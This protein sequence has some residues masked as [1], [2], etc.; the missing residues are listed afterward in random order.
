MRRILSIEAFREVTL[1][2]WDDHIDGAERLRF[3]SAYYAESYLRRFV[4]DPGAEA[5]LRCLIELAPTPSLGGDGLDDILRVAGERVFEKRLK[6]YER[7]LTKYFSD[8]P[9]GPTKPDKPDE[10]D[11]PD[12][13]VEPA[14]AKPSPAVAPPARWELE[15]TVDAAEDNDCFDLSTLHLKAKLVEG[16][17]LTPKATFTVLRNGGVVATGEV[18]TAGDA[19]FDWEIARVRDDEDAWTLEFR[20][21]YEDDTYTGNR[22][23]TVWPRTVRLE[24]N[25]FRTDEP[26]KGFRFS[27]E[28]GAGPQI[29]ETGD[30]GVID[31]PLA[32]PAP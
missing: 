29:A 7:A 18:S 15:A 5:S 24:A 20:F 1:A 32:R 12:D 8:I 11:D 30:G 6:V 3:S 17:A 31:H 2:T 4:A 21:K 10:P 26:T 19:S 25:H 28:Q 13:P 9:I 23:F 27:V 22:V 14:D 16:K